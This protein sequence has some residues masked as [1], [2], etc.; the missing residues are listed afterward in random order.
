[1]YSGVPHTWVRQHGAEEDDLQLQRG[2]GGGG[3]TK[4]RLGTGGGEN[5]GGGEEAVYFLRCDAKSRRVPRV[6]MQIEG[7]GPAPRATCP[8]HTCL[9]TNSRV[10]FSMWPS[11]RLVAML[12]SPILDRPKSVSL[13]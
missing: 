12:M 10:S 6:R 8:P 3:E 9:S 1:M 7:G 2:Q 11:Y 4:A 13:M 5:Y